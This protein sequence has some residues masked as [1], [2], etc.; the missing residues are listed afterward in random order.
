MY[1]DVHYSL[2]PSFVGLFYLIDI[3]MYLQTGQI[4][5]KAQTTSSGNRSGRS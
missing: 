1:V 3:A 2:Q 5:L 4:L